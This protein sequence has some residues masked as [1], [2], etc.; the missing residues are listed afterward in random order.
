MVVSSSAALAEIIRSRFIEIFDASPLVV[1]SPGRVNLIGEHTDYNEG[2]VLPAAINKK[3]VVAISRRA[4]QEIHLYSHDLNSYCQTDLDNIGMARHDWPDYILGV[5]EQVRRLPLPAGGFN[6]VFGG[7]V[8]LGAGMSSS[9]ALECAVIYALNQLFD[10]KLDTLAMVQLAQRAENQYVGVNCGIMD[11]FASMF[12]K[13]DNVIRLDCRTLSYTYVPFRMEGFR[14][15]L[16]D[17]NIK[18]SLAGSEYNI[19]R[20]QCEEGVAMVRLHHP[21]VQSLRD[22]TLE[23]LDAFVLP[24]DAVIYDRCRYVV[25]EN[26]RLLDACALLDQ[27]D[28]KAFGQKMYQSHEGLRSHYEVSCP[29]LDI[30]V[31]A[32]RPLSG[33]YGAR[34]MGG[35]FGGCT[36]NLVE[37]PAVEQVIETVTNMYY[38]KTGKVMR[39]YIVS[40]GNGTALEGSL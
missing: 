23:M 30:L 13:A 31:E 21:D 17:T 9:A 28:M 16:M 4:D 2:Y 25:E 8:P 12:G 6:L 14:I 27:Q 19:R 29:E 5:V 38:S 3:T 37:A 24:K 18:H 10:W 32:A 15:V 20:Q 33:V 36:I 26:Q 35:G 11:Q 34:M 22:V 7:D 1:A 40:I 39:P